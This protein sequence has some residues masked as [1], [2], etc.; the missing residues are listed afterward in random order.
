V[1]PYHLGVHEVVFLAAYALAGI[2]ILFRIVRD[3]GPVAAGG[4]LVAG[5]FLGMSILLD[6]VV[7]YSATSVVIEDL[8]KLAGYGGWSGFWVAVAHAA[9]RNS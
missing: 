7:P 9:A 2:W 1:G 5:G 4:L 3:A 8:L 6:L